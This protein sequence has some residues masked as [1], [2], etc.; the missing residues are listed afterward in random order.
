MKIYQTSNLTL[1]GNQFVSVGGSPG[2]G[3]CA[4]E[5][6]RV[7]SRGRKSVAQWMVYTRPEAEGILT[8]LYEWSNLFEVKATTVEDLHRKVAPELRA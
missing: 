7:T 6:Y 8:L 4:I 1:R 5:V 2:E 3:W